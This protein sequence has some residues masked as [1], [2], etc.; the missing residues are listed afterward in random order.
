MYRSATIALSWGLVALL[1]TPP[2]LAQSAPPDG[3]SLPGQDAFGAI[4][5]VVRFLEADP[6]TD[7]SA[8][9]LE[10]L[11]QHLIDM[12]EVVLRSEGSGGTSPVRRG[13]SGPS[14]PWWCPTRRSSTACPRG[15]PGPSQSRAGSGSR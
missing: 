9:D 12:N 5:E 3:P 15:P 2:L 4:A 1:I 10:R 6:E 7:W 8:V 14:A 13:P 11:R